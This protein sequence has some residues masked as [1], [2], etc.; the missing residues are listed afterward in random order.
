MDVGYRQRREALKNIVKNGMINTYSTKEKAIAA[1]P[2][3]CKEKEQDVFVY[4]V[5]CQSTV[6][7]SLRTRDQIMSL[8]NIIY[9][10]YLPEDYQF[11]NR[12][13]ALREAQ[14]REQRLKR[15]IIVN[16]H[17]KTEKGYRILSYY[18]LTA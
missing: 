10:Y 8:D 6:E 1:I 16:R 11:V 3:F 15:K 7:F 14:V 2:E 9:E 12:D 5:N 13:N 18:T 4:V 17:F